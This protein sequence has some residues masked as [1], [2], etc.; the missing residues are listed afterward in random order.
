ME[1]EYPSK[2]I[3]QEQFREETG[4]VDYRGQTI[5]GNTM[6]LTFGEEHDKGELDLAVSN[7]IAIP[8]E[9]EITN[10]DIMDK[11]NEIEVAINAR[12]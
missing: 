1:Y 12:N 3:N 6:I 9:Q 7:H 5:V 8:P 2:K 11:L 10:N 4:F